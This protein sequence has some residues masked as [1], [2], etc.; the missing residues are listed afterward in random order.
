MGNGK[1]IAHEDR[2]ETEQQEPFTAADA[3][4]GEPVDQLVIGTNEQD[5]GRQ[6]AKRNLFA[7]RAFRDLNRHNGGGATHNHQAVEDIATQHIAYGQ[8]CASFQGGNDTDGQLRSGCA[9]SD[10]GQAND[11]GRD[12]KSFSDGGSSVRQG[13]GAYQDKRQS[14][15]KP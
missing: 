14:Y 11:Q 9:K 15:D 8:S 1:R 4:G 5:K 13:I 6:Q 3:V 10:N 2:E 7:Q 12:M